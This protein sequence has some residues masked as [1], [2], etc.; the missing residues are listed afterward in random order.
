MLSD[1]GQVI[2]LSECFNSSH[3]QNED[4][5]IPLNRASSVSDFLISMNLQPKITNSWIMQH[6]APCRLTLSLGLIV[7]SSHS[8]SSYSWR[9]KSF[10]MPQNTAMGE[11]LSNTKSSSRYLWKH[12]PCTCGHTYNT[13]TDVTQSAQKFEQ[14]G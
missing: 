13:H 8:N 7:I 3:S 11:G 12:T 1:L 10:V 4:D 14:S 6:L 2:H 5:N 9:N